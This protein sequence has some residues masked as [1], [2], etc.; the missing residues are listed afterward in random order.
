MSVY[1]HVE[2]DDLS[3][4]VARYDI[5]TVLSCKGIAVG[6][7]NSIFLLE[8]IGGRFILTLYE[9]R[10]SEADLPFFV[11]LPDHLARRNF[12]VSAMIRDREGVAIQLV[13]GR[14][15]CVIQFLRVVSLTQPTP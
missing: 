3:A 2:P 5:G 7:E 15:A 12:T 13:S 10:V 1:T 6:V 11:V 8:T 9:K 14:S 4:L